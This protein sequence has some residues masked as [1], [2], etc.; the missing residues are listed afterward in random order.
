MRLARRQLASGFDRFRRAV[1]SVTSARPEKPVS[2][3]PRGGEWSTRSLSVCQPRRCRDHVVLARQH[4]KRGAGQRCEGVC[5]HHP[6]KRSE[7]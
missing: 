3:L 1:H 6:L 7:T 2:G 4:Q 5:A